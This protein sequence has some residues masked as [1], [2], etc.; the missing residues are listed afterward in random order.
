MPSVFQVLL[1]TS[2]DNS[3]IVEVSDAGANRPLTATEIRQLA[4]RLVGIA[5]A[6]EKREQL[7]K[8]TPGRLYYTKSGLGIEYIR[9]ARVDIDRCT[10]FATDVDQRG[11]PLRGGHQRE[12]HDLKRYVP[13]SL[14]V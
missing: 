12:I 4:N 10:L 11:K 2:G 3:R 7:S 14:R 9:C 8:F 1:G 5:D 6:R 13:A